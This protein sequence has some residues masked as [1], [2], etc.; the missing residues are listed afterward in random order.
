[1]RWL[2]VSSITI[3]LILSVVPIAFEW[4]WWR[5]EFV[6]LVAIYWSMYSPQYFGVIMAWC[7]GL[8]KD[9]VELAP[10][11]YNALSLLV[12]A[13]IAHLSYQRIK[14][15]ALWH[16][17][18]WVFVLIGIFQLFCHWVSGFMG[19]GIE[20]PLFLISALVSAFLWPIVVIS[21]GSLRLR[22]R[23]Y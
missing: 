8:L 23:L 19:K 6:A 12:V 9:I 16:Q 21:L 2:I 7:C 13:Y 18:A 11:G 1:M 5:P 14:N 17:A 10:L 22:L 15:Y 20:S 3:A 4:R